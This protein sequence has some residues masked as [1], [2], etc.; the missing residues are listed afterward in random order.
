MI[1][2]DCDMLLLTETW[3][4]DNET[5][6]YD[7]KNYNAVHSCRDFSRGGGASVY[8]KDTLQ[9]CEI[10][11]S[12]PN[13]K[14]NWISVSVG[15]QS[16]KITVIYI[17]PSLSGVELQSSLEEILLK[18]PKKHLVV[19]DFNV[20]LLEQSRETSNYRNLVTL[21]N[22]KFHNVITEE[23]ATR[24]TRD[25]CSI[26]DHVLS[27][28]YSDL[29]CKISVRSNS[30]SDH[31][32][33]SITVEDN[34]KTLSKKVIHKITKIDFKK[35]TNIF[36]KKVL[37]KNI[38]TF[39]G[40]TELIMESRKESEY[41][42]TFK[43]RENNG[44]I[45]QEV[46]EMM[47]VKEEIYKRKIQNVDDEKL[48]AEFKTIKNQINN[49][50][51]SLKNQYFR[52]EWAQAGTNIKKQW[53]F[54]NNFFKHRKPE[55]QIPEIKIN[56][57]HYDNPVEIANNLNNHFSKVGNS[58]VSNL[59]KEIRITRPNG[60]RACSEVVS[61][62]STEVQLT[63]ETEIMEIMLD[64]KKNSAPGHD[65]VT[66]NDLLNLKNV[67]AGVIA[68]LVNDALLS[69]CFPKELK[70]SKI[71]PIFKSGDKKCVNNYR[72]IS[73]LSVFSK[74]VEKI[75]KK[76]MLQYIDHY[77]STD[78]Y[79]YGFLKNSSTLS[80][81]VD[82]VNHISKALDRGEI[83]VVVY[84]D[85][86]KAF[87]VVSINILLRKL[88]YLGFTGQMLNLIQ[89]Y[90]TDR[91]QYVK[92]NNVNSDVAS[93]TYGVPQ[94]S[95]L[96]P[97]LYSLYVLNLKCAE[98]KSR[99]FTFAD[100]TAM[101]YT[102]TDEQELCREI[103]GDLKKYVDWL[104][105]NKL[106]I[107]ID[108]TKYMV[109]TQKNKR[110]GNLKLNINNVELEQ[111]TKI[112]YLGLI[113]DDRLSWSDHI[114]HVTD[115][116]VPMISAIFKCRSY[117][118]DKTKNMVYNAF[119]LSRV[120]YLL[121]IW[122]MCSKIHFN[123]IQT[124]QNKILKIMYNYDRLTNTDRLFRELKV[125]KLDNLLLIEQCKL[126]YKV[127]HR[128][129]KS[130]VNIILSNQVHNYETRIINNIYQINTRTNIGL[131]N[132]IVNAAKVFNRLPSYIKSIN[133]YTLFIKRL[134]NRFLQV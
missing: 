38:T 79:Q 129:Q 132:P 26:I 3:L 45:N 9:F 134:K 89:S 61:Q 49:K 119:F 67:L 93:S 2:E 86:R 71:S 117:L 107:N 77:V 92:V 55:T 75:I 99:Y 62:S 23:S 101:V 43:A 46:L 74:I 130:N 113:V 78:E 58:I 29:N 6:L 1:N 5:F 122:G 84:I 31:N 37:N 10:G 13:S 7:I 59:D 4:K 83:A 109:F 69:G 12:E 105:S 16:L 100:D 44:W 73:V 124:L 28:N 14:I 121:P 35:F 106:Q 21:N 66:V 81:T 94:G 18:Y 50:I 120:R 95:V 27:D 123:K 108:K 24:I 76:R 128:H 104:Y 115:K 126:V 133:S 51:K 22:F 34:I 90:L 80:A 70:I 48:D 42:I 52:K 102:G 64:L 25:T 112:R 110:I 60:F 96:G 39:G 82:F 127:L 11:R 111:V 118:T 131:H 53:K 40:L 41:E 33:L 47:K 36:H 65:E 72:P 17:P 15:K 116:V 87:D 97:L 98:L 30:L 56:N 85:L 88:E 125:H 19:G 57:V 63:N 8:I 91:K 32:L 20:N 54:I 114:D 68:R 103:D